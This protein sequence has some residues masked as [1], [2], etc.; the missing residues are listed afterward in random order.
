MTR[1]EQIKKDLQDLV[2]ALKLAP[3]VADDAERNKLLTK[4]EGIRR[5]L[6]LYAEETARCDHELSYEVFPAGRCVKCGA[7]D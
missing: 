6:A 2:E 5:K 1:D 4:V 3:D 7:H